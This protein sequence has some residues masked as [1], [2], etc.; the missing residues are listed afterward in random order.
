MG[1]KVSNDISESTHNTHPQKS[2]AYIPLVGLFLNVLK[3]SEISIFEFWTF[4]N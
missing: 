2:H 4:D 1:W 3:N